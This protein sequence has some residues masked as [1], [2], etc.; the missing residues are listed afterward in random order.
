[1]EAIRKVKELQPDLILLDL[2][3]PVLNGIEVARQV[4][5]LAPAARIC[6][7]TLESSPETVGEALTLGTGYVHKPR[8]AS[9]LM[10]AIEAV[11]QGKRFVSSSLSLAYA[12]PP[13]P[14]LMAPLET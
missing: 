1:M 6:F 3:L 2:A 4:R 14:R 5:D 7:L 13:K 10:P 9:D 12:E 11:L 8:L